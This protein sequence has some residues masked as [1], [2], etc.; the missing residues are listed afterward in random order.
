MTNIRQ[1][2]LNKRLSLQ[3]SQGDLL[4]KG[5][6]ASV[7]EIRE[8][9][10]IKHVKMPDGEWKVYQDTKRTYGGKE[11]VDKILAKHWD[12]SESAAAQRVLSIMGITS[13]DAPPSEKVTQLKQ[14]GVNNPRTLA[15]I[16]GAN[17]S[18]IIQTEP[19]KPSQDEIASLEDSI[20]LL[21][22]ADGITFDDSELSR[23]NALTGKDAVDTVQD[24]FTD[25]V[26]KKERKLAMFYGTGGVGK[27]YGVKQVLLNPNTING[28]TGEP[29]DNKL[30]EYDSE[31]APTSEQYDL[32][33]FTGKI[34]P[35]K[36]YR[37]LYE[38]NGKV[39]MFDDA[40]SVL[41]DED[42][43]N[44]LKA[45]TDT[46]LEDVV[47]DGASIKGSGGGDQR[48]PTRFKFTGGV[49]IISNLTEKKLK[50]VASP[51]LE[52][53]ALALDVSRTME[54]TIDKL[55]RIKE[56][57]PFEDRDGEPIHVAL[58]HREAAIDFIKKY[59]NHMPVTQVNGRTLGALA[60]LHLR[61][62][63][64]FDLQPASFYSDFAARSLMNVKQHQIM[65][66][67]K[68]R[69]LEEKKQIEKQRA[70]HS[71]LQSR[72]K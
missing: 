8:W 48:L 10:G 28:D 69:L 59:Q 49:I 6:R 60:L 47:W 5:K 39:I 41:L 19:S 23:V 65:D 66:F 34:T 3:I 2:I 63:K 32:I 22:E 42:S 4:T 16:S 24:K 61:G 33:K 56:K 17:F 29:F 52:S 14:S 37:A 1:A 21:L 64:K 11:I 62:G 71:A 43:V 18:D 70:I 13:S 54:E 30:V 38:H 68:S 44:L 46:T 40:D 31:L 12:V 7:G 27:T 36:L 35:S 26:A 58:E 67:H 25:M 45:A 50:A 72:M 20:A 55:D 15:T 9:D 53:R 51:L 57:L